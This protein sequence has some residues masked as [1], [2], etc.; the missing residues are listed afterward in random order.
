MQA[1]FQCLQ[2]FLQPI[3]ALAHP[4]HVLARGRGF[5]LGR[6]RAVHARQQVLHRL[7]GVLL[8][9]LL[10]G[11]HLVGDRARH[12]LQLA[13]F[14]D[15]LGQVFGDLLRLLRIRLLLPGQIGQ[16]FLHGFKL[17]GTLR[18]ELHG[19][20]GR[21][22]TRRCLAHADI[23]LPLLVQLGELLFEGVEEPGTL[24]VE[25]RRRGWWVGGFLPC[26]RVLFLLAGQFS[27]LAG[28]VVEQLLALG[29]EL[30]CRGRHRRRRAGLGIR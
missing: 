15:G 27:E 12:H 25:L 17:L 3:G 6:G 20:A 30:R 24:G 14:V 28:H 19:L 21:W 8:E 29:V 13:R 23:L 9:V 2:L 16:L 26:P 22:S 4:L 5:L 11:V 10:R 1:F 18:I 7:H